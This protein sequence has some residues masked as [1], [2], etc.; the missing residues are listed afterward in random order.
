MACHELSWHEPSWHG[1]GMAW[2]VPSWPAMAMAPNGAHAMTHFMPSARQE[3]ALSLR[4]CSR[5]A[6]PR[7]ISTPHSPVPAYP[8]QQCGC[9]RQ[10]RPSMSGSPQTSAHPASV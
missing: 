7:P 6:S 9:T 2:Q 3:T 4:T 1:K 10:R 5:H 8:G